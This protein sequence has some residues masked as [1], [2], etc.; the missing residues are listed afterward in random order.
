M[1]KILKFFNEVKQELLKVTWLSNKETMVSTMI[2]LVVVVVFS[3]LFV[4]VDFM[5][6]HFVQFIL[7]LRF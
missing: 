1:L 4:L 2:V 7:N 5:I 6:F 3:S